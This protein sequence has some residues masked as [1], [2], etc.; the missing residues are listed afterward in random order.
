M[1]EKLKPSSIYFT[2]MDTCFYLFLSSTLNGSSI[3][4]YIDIIGLSFYLANS[5]E[6]VTMR[7]YPVDKICFCCFSLFLFFFIW[8]NYSSMT[9]FFSIFLFLKENRMLRL[10]IHAQLFKL[11]RER[12]RETSIPSVYI[13]AEHISALNNRVMSLCHR[14][15]HGSQHVWFSL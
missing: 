2:A 12:E 15:V 14:Q 11:K 1:L 8:E 4:F 7:A 3:N 5:W 10:S 13:L 9:I 6:N